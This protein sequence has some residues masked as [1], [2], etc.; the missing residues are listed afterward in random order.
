MLSHLTTYE[1]KQ[2]CVVWLQNT[3]VIR[4][5]LKDTH[6]IPAPQMFWPKEIWSKFGTKLEV[7]FFSTLQFGYIFSM[8]ENSLKRS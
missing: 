5:Y 2:R 6:E 7:R 3:N 1:L 4:D 8:N